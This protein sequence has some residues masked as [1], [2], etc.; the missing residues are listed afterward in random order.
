MKKMGGM[1]IMKSMRMSQ[2]PDDRPLNL[3]L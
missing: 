1:G 2:I 3:E